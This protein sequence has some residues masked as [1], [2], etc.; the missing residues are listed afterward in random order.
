MPGREAG[1]DL[2]ADVPL[3]TDEPVRGAFAYLEHPGILSLSGIEQIRRFKEKQLPYGPLWY[4]TGLDLVEFGPGTA[5]YRLPVT[6]WLR[7]GAGVI[8]GGALA[9]AAD[10]ALGSAIF[11]TLGPGK[12]LATSDIALNFLR[13]PGNDCDAIIAKGRLIQ[14]GRS[15]GLSEATVEDVTGHLLAHATSRCVISEVPGPL[16]DPPHGSVPWPEYPGPH[17]FER[18][19]VGKVVPRETWDRMDGIEVMRAWQQGELPRTPLSNLLGAE[20]RRVEQGAVTLTMSASPWFGGMGG[21]LYGGALAL[22]ADYG[23]HG[24]VTSAVPAGTSWATLDLRVRFLRPVIPDRRP[25]EVRAAVAHR[26]RRIAV[27]SAE[28]L[29][30]DGKVAALAD[31]S[32]MLLP[33]RP[34]AHPAATIDQAL[35]A[36]GPTG[37]L[38]HARLADALR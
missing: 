15:Q 19:P 36:R 9:F 29:T 7:S 12:V 4:L 14:A 8:T 3:P 25:L 10:G 5:T 32:L 17:P 27:V 37:R 20:V 34:W 33:G 35:E 11:T 18:P 30:T 2:V 6:G 1:G 16:S 13:L 23:I 28:V 31:S 38:R 24:A 21:A 22:L 26:G